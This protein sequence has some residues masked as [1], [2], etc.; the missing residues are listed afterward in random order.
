MKVHQELREETPKCVWA[1]WK[2]A[3][4]S[5]EHLWVQAPHGFCIGTMTPLKI[6]YGQETPF[7][8]KALTKS[9]EECFPEDPLYGK[10]L[11]SSNFYVLGAL[12][13]A[14]E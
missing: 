3:P 4:G 5:T 2:A 11:I 13:R 14:E 12:L 6:R 9:V 8:A 10:S 7:S 1:W